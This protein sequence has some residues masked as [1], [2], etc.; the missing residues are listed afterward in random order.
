MI[1]L[2]AG[3][4]IIRRPGLGYLPAAQRH[5][6]QRGEEERGAEGGEQGADGDAGAGGR[7]V[8]GRDGG[9][10]GG[11][12]AAGEGGGGEPALMAEE[13][14]RGEVAGGEGNEDGGGGAL[15][16]EEEVGGLRHGERRGREI[17][18][19]EMQGGDRGMIEQ[20]GKL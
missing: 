7:D 15:G 14:A 10:E 19:D 2:A 3:T 1:T 8:E 11:D 6:Q 16:L 12:E 5:D 4:Q 9:G 20:P 17:G 13:G 18:Q